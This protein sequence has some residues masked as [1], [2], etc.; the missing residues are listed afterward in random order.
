MM[1]D[2]C[3]NVGIEKRGRSRF[4]YYAFSIHH[5]T[6]T[7]QHLSLQP[8]AA[9]PTKEAT[10]NYDAL[11]TP[12]NIVMLLAVFGSLFALY[13]NFHKVKEEDKKRAELDKEHAREEAI[14]KKT[15]EIQLATIASD[16]KDFKGMAK[17]NAENIQEIKLDTR[18]NG[19]RIDSIEQQLKVYW[20][21]VDEMRENMNK[22]EVKLNKKVGKEV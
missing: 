2:E 4:F 3:Y 5:S 1:N 17:A 6:F 19:V 15:V 18:N 9:L 8:K 20:Q 12:N 11:F 13:M 16:V 10:M 21:R 14:W 22:V 7:I